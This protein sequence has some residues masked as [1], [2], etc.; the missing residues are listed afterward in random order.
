MYR[1]E[2]NKLPPSLNRF[3]SGKHWSKRK[4]IKDEWLYLM[5]D[6][7]NT[8]NLPRPL[9]QSG[10]PYTI[11]CVQFCKHVVRDC[12]NAVIGTKLCK[13][14]LT[15]W[16]YME[17]DNPEFIERDIL[18]SKRGKSNKMILMIFPSGK[19]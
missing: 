17:D 5:R 12:D 6:A 10:F 19:Q 2:I 15:H 16:G 18:E 14:A 9:P 8:A 3:W 11:K 4:Q 13:D 7:F 1:I